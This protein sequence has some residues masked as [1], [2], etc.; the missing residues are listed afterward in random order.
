MV[1]MLMLPGCVGFHYQW[2]HAKGRTQQVEESSIEGLWT[3]SWQ[4]SKSSHRGKLRCVIR[5]TSP[6][7]YA[8]L[9]RA[10][11]ARFIT[12]NFRINCIV[13]SDQGTWRFSGTKDLGI[14]GGNFSHSGT[15]SA[16]AIRA[17]YK[18]EKGD[19]GIFTLS[20]PDASPH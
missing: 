3:G 17:E 4:S 16:T 18:S 13:N 8:F 5:K 2:H 10:T 9:Y 7:S 6:D 19:G 1:M 12:G 14:L 11:W 20:R 15:G